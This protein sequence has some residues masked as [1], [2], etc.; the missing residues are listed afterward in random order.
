MI[1]TDE[2]VE[3]MAFSNAITDSDEIDYDTVYKFSKIIEQAVI[4]KLKQKATDG[5][6]L[7]AWQEWHDFDEDMPRMN[8]SFEKGWKWCFKNIFGEG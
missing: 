2:E 3:N 7:Q 5:D 1:L 6:C 8:F 4:K